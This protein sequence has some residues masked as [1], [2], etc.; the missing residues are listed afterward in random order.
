M[1]LWDFPG[2]SC[3]EKVESDCNL[4]TSYDKF[5]K[6]FSIIF[7]YALAIFSVRAGFLQH[8]LS[9]SNL[10]PFSFLKTLLWYPCS[11]VIPPTNNMD[12]L[13]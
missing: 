4:E 3:N 7:L 10:I 5:T 12:D 8:G 6:L 13:Q 2:V 9:L 1:G 11:Q